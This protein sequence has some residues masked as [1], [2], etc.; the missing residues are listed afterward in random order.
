MGSLGL[1]APL[2]PGSGTPWVPEE[3]LTEGCWQLLRQGLPGLALP[4]P[5]F[6]VL[7]LP[8]WQFPIPDPDKLPLKAWHEVFEPLI[9]KVT[10]LDQHIPILPAGSA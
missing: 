2:R 4:H 6:F 5:S 7:A 3:G 10:H 9:G 8:T 1:G